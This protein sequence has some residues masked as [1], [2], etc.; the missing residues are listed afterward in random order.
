MVIIE[1]HDQND[2]Y[3]FLREECNNIVHYFEDNDYR[4]IYKDFSNTIY[5]S[6]DFYP[7]FTF[8]Q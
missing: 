8:G 6:K 1:L 3:L 4:V 2:T 7:E 5:V